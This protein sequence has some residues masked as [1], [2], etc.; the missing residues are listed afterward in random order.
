MSHQGADTDTK[1][2]R[3]IAIWGTTLGFG[4]AKSSTPFLSR[5]GLPKSLLDAAEGEV[6]KMMNG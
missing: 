2:Q 6:G 1:A 4:A 5:L 3:W